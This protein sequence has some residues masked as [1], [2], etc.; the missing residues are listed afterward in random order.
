MANWI[1]HPLILPGNSVEL[2]SMEPH[3]F[4]AL[5]KVAKDRR[6]WEFYPYDGSDSTTFQQLFKT[7]LD[8]RDNGNQFP[9][10][11]YHKSSNLVIGSTRFMDIQPKHKKLEIGST[12]LHPNYWATEVNPECKLL[13]LQYCFETLGTV[14]VQLKTDERNL[15]SRKAIEKVGGQFEGIFRNDMIR[16]NNTRRNSAYYSIVEEEWEEKKIALLA[17]YDLKRKNNKTG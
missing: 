2:V 17:L 9:F 15:R 8:E 11:I 3:H 7:S 5:E 12:W 14:R 13:L 10:T 4:A 16:D 1:Q 6:V